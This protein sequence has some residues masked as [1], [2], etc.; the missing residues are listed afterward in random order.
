MWGEMSGNRIRDGGAYLRR[1][2]LRLLLRL[3]SD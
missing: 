2:L 1:R 3:E